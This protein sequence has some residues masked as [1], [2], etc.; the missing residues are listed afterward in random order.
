[1]GCQRLNIVCNM[2]FVSREIHHRVL[3]V[4]LAVKKVI[5]WC[6]LIFSGE[7]SSMSLFS[8]EEQEVVLFSPMS[9][10]IT[11]NGNPVK[12]VVLERRVK[13]LGEK[14]IEDSIR[15]DEKGWFSFG[16]LTD[17]VKINPLS[18]FVVNQYIYAKHDGSAYKVWIMGKL[19]GNEYSELGGK[20]INF[21][22]ELTDPFVRVEVDNGQL[23]TLCKWDD[24]E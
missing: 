11:I 14:E 22:C 4:M 6:L 17:N 5:V 20:P 1:M 13:W 23:G 12:G 7:S 9:G 24:V 16:E 15:T 2:V 10:Y 21:R 8:S 3:V 18:Q 19:D